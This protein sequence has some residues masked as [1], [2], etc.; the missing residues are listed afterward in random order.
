MMDFSFL[1]AV[2][3]NKCFQSVALLGFFH[4]EGVCSFV[5]MQISWFDFKKEKYPHIACVIQEETENAF[6]PLLDSH[7]I[8]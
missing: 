4:S 8:L 1:S 3:C 6:S 5:S 7:V 2:L